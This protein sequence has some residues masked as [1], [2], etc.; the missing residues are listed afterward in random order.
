VQQQCLPGQPNPPSGL[1]TRMEDVQDFSWTCRCSPPSTLAPENVAS[2]CRLPSQSCSKSRWVIDCPQLAYGVKVR[3]NADQSGQGVR[4]QLVGL[5]IHAANAP[6]SQSASLN[7]PQEHA[8]AARRCL[9]GNLASPLTALLCH[10]V[11]AAQAPMPV[12]LG[13]LTL[14]PSDSASKEYVPVESKWKLH[15]DN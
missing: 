2:I 14:C 6:L 5:A 8:L 7:T 4:A 11:K 12:R 3:R 13:S 1:K 15:H 9:A 10:Q